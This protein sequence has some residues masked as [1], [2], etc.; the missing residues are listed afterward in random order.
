MTWHHKTP[1]G[2]HTQNILRHKSYQCFLRSVSQGKTKIEIKS[3]NKQLG[4]N[5]TYKLLHSKENHKQNEK[6]TYRLGENIY[7]WH[8]WQGLNFQII[9]NLTQLNNKKTNNPILKWEED[10]NRHLSKEDIQL[11]NRHMKRCST[12]LIIRK[13]Q[14]KTTMRYHLIP[15]RM[16]IIKMSTSNKCWRGC[17]EREP[18]S[19]VGGNVH[20]CSHCGK[21]YGGS[22]KN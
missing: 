6:T 7:K 21:Q 5:Q 15:V 1:R 14:I 22:S 13:M 11:A 18:S 3:K 20:S 10:L 16:A 8:D 12:L 19:T 4:P 2:E 17:G 9:Q